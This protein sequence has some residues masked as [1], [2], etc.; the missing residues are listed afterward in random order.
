LAFAAAVFKGEKQ[1][2]ECPRLKKEVIEKYADRAAV[3]LPVETQAEQA[4]AQLKEN[5]AA[6]D[7]AWSANRLGLDFEDGKLIIKCLGKDVG[8]DAKGNIIT[9]I[10]VHSWITIPILN[11]IIRGAGVPPSGE[12]VPFRELEGGKTWYRLFGQRCERPLK[13]VADYYT[14]LFEDMIRLFE[15][16]QV[17]NHYESDISLVLQPLPK[18]PILICYWRPDDRLESD[19]NIFFDATAAQNLN[20]ESIFTLSTGLVRMFEKIALRH[21]QL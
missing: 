1:L 19:L 21:G 9:D 11:Y 16:R 14:D 13:N 12:W 17:G 3:R 10:H 20:I 2:D 15:G 18:M 7:L 5:V 6:L 4:L 8:V